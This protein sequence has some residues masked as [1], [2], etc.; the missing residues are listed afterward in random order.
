MK[1]RFCTSTLTNIVCDLGITPLAN[2]YLKKE[3]LSLREPVF[4]LRVFVCSSCFLVQLEQFETPEHIFSDYAYFSSYSESFLKQAKRYVENVTSRFSLGEKSQIVEVA[5]NDGYLLQYFL[6]KNYRVL[7]IEPAHNVALVAQKKGIQTRS[8]F[9]GTKLAYRLVEEG[10]SADLLIANNVLAHVPDLKD[11]VEGLAI[12][13]KPEGVLTLEF[14]H[15]LHL[16]EQVQFDTI[17]HEHFS[18]FSFYTAKKILESKGLYIFDVEELPSHGGSLR[19]Y[20][21][22]KATSSLAAEAL[23]Q[24]EKKAA[25]FSLSTYVDYAL[26]IER[27]KKELLSFLEKAK[28]EGKK[29]A[30][31]GAPAKGNTFLNYCGITS[32]LISYT[33]DLSPHKQGLYLPGSKIPIFSPE[34]IFQEKPDYILVL[35]W[36]LREEIILQM[37]GVRQWGAKFLCAIPHLTVI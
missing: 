2:R 29:I 8:E 19:L 20:V 23:I 17:Y 7:G 10:F 34:K 16:I 3:E 27:V 18:Y 4:P 28:K 25:L 6:E 15:L 32:S 5:S 31:Y 37:E 11:F 24:K 36:N 14:P 21:G 35:P 26:G 13:L 9:F 12:L 22:K 30:A 1:C 33:V